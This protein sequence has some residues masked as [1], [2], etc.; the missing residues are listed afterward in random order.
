MQLVKFRPHHF[1]CAFCFEGKGYSPAFVKNFYQVLTQVQNVIIEVVEGLDDIC[2]PCPNHAQSICRSQQ[3]VQALDHAHANILQLKPADQL[4]WSQAVE[5]IKQHMTVEKFHL[6]C[7][8]CNWKKLGVCEA[9]LIK[10]SHG[11]L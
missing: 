2:Q 6:A 7:Q 4:T 8:N 5:K 1:L 3:T 11:S 9:K 10:A